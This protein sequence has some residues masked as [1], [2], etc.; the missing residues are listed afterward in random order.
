ME[1]GVLGLH[2]KST[3]VQGMEVLIETKG[4]CRAFGGLMAVNGVDMRVVRGRTK[5][6][7]GPNGAGKSTLLNLIAGVYQATAGDVFVGGKSIA[8]L[9]THEVAALGLARTF[10]NVQLFENMTVIENVMVGCHVW[11]KQGIASGA[12]RWIGHWREERLISKEAMRHLELVGLADDAALP[13]G[14]LPFGKQRLLEIARALASRPKVLLLDEPASGLSTRETEG[15]MTLLRRIISEGVTVL[16]VDHDMQ[17]VME[18]SDEVTVLDQGR[19]IAEGAPEEVQNDPRVI[20]AY[21][22]AEA[23]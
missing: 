23:K 9:Q 17:F 19:K 18:M 4:V 13:A 21:L 8:G 3:A 22:G 20:A 16:L 5:A 11:T 1:Y 6:L 12:L 15:L 7:I 14:S 10:Q 2:S